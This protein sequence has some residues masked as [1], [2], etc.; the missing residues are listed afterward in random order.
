MA[1]IIEK[2]DP[3][4]CEYLDPE[5]NVL[6][7]EIVLPGVTKENIYLKVNTSSLLLLASCGNVNYAKYVSFGQPVVPEKGHAYYDHDLLRIRIP[8]RA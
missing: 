6:T 5:E 8:L 1:R 3:E 4:M 2:I 7:I